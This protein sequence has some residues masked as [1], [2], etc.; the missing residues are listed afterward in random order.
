MTIRCL[1]EVFSVTQCFIV[2]LCACVVGTCVPVLW[3]RRCDNPAV[4]AQSQGLGTVQK[5]FPP[6]LSR[7]YSYP[8]PVQAHACAAVGGGAQAEVGCVGVCVSVDGGVC[9]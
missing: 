7:S 4:L 1:F 5:L 6:T 8:S 9:V 2:Y 3:P